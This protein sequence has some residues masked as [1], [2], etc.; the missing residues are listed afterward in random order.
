M[1]AGA[2]SNNAG[3]ANAAEAS[4]SQ[5]YDTLA[6]AQ[7]TMLLFALLDSAVGPILS[8]GLTRDTTPTVVLSLNRL[9]QSGDTL[10]V[11]RDSADIFTSTST[12]S[13]TF[14][15]DDS[16]APRPLDDYLYTARITDAVGNVNPLLLNHA[17]TVVP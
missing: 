12:S 15:F 4:A 8:G 13:A 17:V 16:V 14:T 5:G 9:L 10:H 2:F 11:L 7:L 3:T 6:P 1:A